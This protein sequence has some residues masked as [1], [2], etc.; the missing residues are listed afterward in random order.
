MFIFIFAANSRVYT[1]LLLAIR[2]RFKSEI[3]RGPVVTCRN[4]GSVSY[5]LVNTADRNEKTPTNTRKSVANLQ[6]DTALGDY[7]FGTRLD[8]K[9]RLTNFSFLFSSS[10]YGRK[11][12]Q[13]K[14]LYALTRVD[15]FFSLDPEGPNACIDCFSLLVYGELSFWIRC[16]PTA[17]D[18]RRFDY[19]SR[20]RTIIRFIINARI[21]YRNTP[22]S[23]QRFYFSHFST[24]SVKKDG[25]IHDRR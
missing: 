7:I 22:V 10:V 20:K 16:R 21:S 25:K 6:A 13:Q 19:D 9:C 3:D 8:T 18:V 15:I 24:V 14:I 2:A 5:S 11:T 12:R 4:P 1:V 23:I 17:S